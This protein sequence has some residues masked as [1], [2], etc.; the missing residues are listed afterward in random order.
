MSRL[1]EKWY[2]G[3]EPEYDIDSGHDGQILGADGA[4]VA[5]E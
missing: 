2:V 3:Y 1:P 4:L 5:T